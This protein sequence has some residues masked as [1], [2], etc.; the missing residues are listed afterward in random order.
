MAVHGEAHR[1]HER[2]ANAIRELRSVYLRIAEITGGQ[3][4]QRE[5]VD[6]GVE[7]N[8]VWQ[9]RDADIQDVLSVNW[10]AQ[11]E[12]AAC[13]FPVSAL[14][15]LMKAILALDRQSAWFVQVSWLELTF[16]LRDKGFTFWHRPAGQWKPVAEGFHA[17]RPTLS[18]SW[19]FVRG[20]GRFLFR[21]LELDECC[22]GGINLFD[23]GV[24]PFQD[25]L[26][27]GVDEGVLEQARVSLAKLTASRPLRKAADFS[28]PF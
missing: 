17:L 28:R 6:T 3:K 21:E 4:V 22:C 7:G 2:W 12:A 19:A 13:S 27:L 23:V 24:F 20:A 5:P 9:A 15:A 11:L 25:G 10:Q 18:G 14:V 1:N 16:M 8:V 26:M